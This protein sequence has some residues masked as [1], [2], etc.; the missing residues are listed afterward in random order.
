[1]TRKWNEWAPLPIRVVFGG[2]IMYHGY[3]KLF[4]AE[5]H[6]SFLY[7]MEQAGV[8]LPHVT[9]WLVAILEF[10][11]G[12]ALVVG[13]FVVTA[14]VLLVIELTI[15]VAMALYH[16]GFPPPLNPDQPL[17]GYASSFLYICGLLA[18]AIGGAG[19]FSLTR[20]VVPRPS[21]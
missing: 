9:A 4:T 18:L 13:A 20:M 2:F 19:G 16:G 5:G 1:M 21:D 10:F 11:G 17:P 15:N 7:M 6:A 14:S 12:L 8:P 3:P